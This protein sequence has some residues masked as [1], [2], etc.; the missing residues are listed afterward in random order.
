M[1]SLMR[2]P[3]PTSDAQPA[4][5]RAYAR[6]VV[7]TLALLVAAGFAMLFVPAPPLPLVVGAVVLALLF[8]ALIALR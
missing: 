5:D 6:V 3:P 4:S 1:V 2:E 8:I 7:A